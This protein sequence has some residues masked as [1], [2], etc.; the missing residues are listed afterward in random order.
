MVYFHGNAEDLGHNEDFLKDLREYFKISVLAME[1][2]GYGFHAFKV[3]DGKEDT[4]QKLSC[5]AKK[6]ITNGTIVMDH[7]LRPIEE[8]GMGFK[9][10][11]VVFF[12]RSIGTGPAT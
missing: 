7:V 12:G 3:K 10:E 1:Y 2:P 4:T 6:I 11:N 5:S 9:A 8:G